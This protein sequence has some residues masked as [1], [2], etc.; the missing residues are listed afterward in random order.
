M[1]SRHS[2]I[3]RSGPAGGRDRAAGR[4][5]EGLHAGNGGRPFAFRTKRTSSR[6]FGFRTFRNGFLNDPRAGKPWRVNDLGAAVGAQS[7]NFL[8]APAGC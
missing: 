2:W 1:R 5:P 7:A 8:N 4:C 3:G 6:A